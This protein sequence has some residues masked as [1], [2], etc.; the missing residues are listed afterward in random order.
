[1]R[2]DDTESLPNFSLYQTVSKTTDSTLK[3]NI[4]CQAKKRNALYFNYQ[5]LNFLKVSI[6]SIHALHLNC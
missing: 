1:M 3:Y 2:I 4:I 6:T 5:E